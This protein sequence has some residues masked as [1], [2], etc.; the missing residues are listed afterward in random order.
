MAHF[1]AS[2]EEINP[3]MT[4]PKYL[5]SLAVNACS[6]RNVAD[7]A[8]EIRTLHMRRS[9]IWFG[10]EVIAR[11]RQSWSETTPQEQLQEA[12]H[13]LYQIG[14]ITAHTSSRIELGDASREAVEHSLAAFQSGTGLVGLS[15]GLVD[16]DAKLGGISDTDLVILGGRP[17]MGKTA[18]VTN[19]GLYLAEQGIPVDFY[20]MEMGA[21]QLAN[22]LL[23]ER[24]QISSHDIRRG[25]LKDDQFR[26]LMD[27]GNQFG[28]LPFSIEQSGGLTIDRLATF[29]RRHKRQRRTG[30]IIVD[31]LQLMK[32]GKRD[33]S[34]T[35]EPTLIVTGKPPLCSI[36]NGRRPN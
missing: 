9:L 23:G 6:L 7:Y 32:S 29:A 36:E 14:N 8:R 11:A 10:E 35:Q 2:H 33:S 22:R 31:Y 25:R 30:L 5:G 4:V 20:S 28:R 15:T 16:L 24:A 26:K 34:R 3:G 12:E 13:E 27:I 19:I 18:L 17:A 1:F 21:S